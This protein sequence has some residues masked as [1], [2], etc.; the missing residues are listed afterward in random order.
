MHC[1]TCG[2]PMDVV[3]E[4]GV[5]IDRC[6]AC[7]T[8]F[9]DSGELDAWDGPTGRLA[10]NVM[11]LALGSE[12]AGPP[13]PRCG[14]ATREVSSDSVTADACQS[15]RGVL[16]HWIG[17]SAQDPPRRQ[18]VPVD[19]DLA[20][21]AGWVAADVVVDDPVDAVDAA[22]TGVELAGDGLEAVGEGAWMLGSVAEGIGD[23]LSSLLQGLTDLNP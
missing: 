15:C 6:R 11:V 20:Q 22:A 5:E 10:Y 14:G 19:S 4:R 8:I 16:L 1:G 9:F 18:R 2:S 21:T 17:G 3:E 23:L 7:D 13:C 12:V